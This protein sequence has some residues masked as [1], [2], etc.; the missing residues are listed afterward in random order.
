MPQNFELH[1]NFSGKFRPVK[2][3]AADQKKSFHQTSIQYTEQQQQQ[4][5]QLQQQQQHQQQGPLILTAPTRANKNN[6]GNNNKNGGGQQGNGG[7]AYGGGGGGGPPPSLPSPS[8]LPT[9]TPLPVIG[10]KSGIRKDSQS[11]AAP[12]STFYMG[13]NT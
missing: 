7:Y 13:K 11:C 6:D 5:Q 10:G 8:A 1:S 12:T 3:F 4:Q 2:S 9:K